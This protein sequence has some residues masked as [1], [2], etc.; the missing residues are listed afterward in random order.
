MLSTRFHKLTVSAIRLVDF[1]KSPSLWAFSAFLIVNSTWLREEQPLNCCS[2]IGLA[3]RVAQMLGESTYG[4]QTVLEIRR[5]I[6]TPHKGL[7]REP[8]R[9]ET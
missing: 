9:F 3:F 1:P 6:A 8:A 2:F 5:L 4:I 7:H